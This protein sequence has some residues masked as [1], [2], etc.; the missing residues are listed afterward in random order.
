MTLNRNPE[1]FF[2]QIEQAAFEPSALVPGHRR[3]ARTRCCSAGCSPTRTPTATGS[4]RTTCSC[5]STGPAR[6]E[7]LRSSTGRWPTTTPPTT[8]STRRTRTARGTPTRS[9]GED[10]WEADGEMVRRPTPCARTTTTSARPARWSARSGTTD[11]ADFVK[12]VAGHLLGGVKPTILERAFEYWKNVDADTG[13]QI[14]ELVNAG[15]PDEGPGPRR[16]PS[17]AAWSRR[18]PGRTPADRQRHHTGGPVPLGAGSRCVRRESP[19]CRTSLLPTPTSAPSTSS[20]S[21]TSSRPSRCPTTT[22][23]R[24]SP[25]WCRVPRSGRR[26]GRCCTCTGSRTTLPDPGG[27]L[28]DGPRLRLLRPR[29]PEVRPVPA[30]APD[31]QLRHRPDGVLRGARRR[32]TPGSSTATVT[33]TSSSPR[34]RPAG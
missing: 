2:A 34:T 9:A 13:K 28:L 10:G 12:T 19:P 21:P 25:R 1:N 30:R 22:R 23:G 11:R 27:R 8:R 15:L 7:H 14:E 6:G 31:P 18:P 33:T 24:S 20:V 32:P 17:G 4:A 5:R 26:A 3:S 16:R 29:P